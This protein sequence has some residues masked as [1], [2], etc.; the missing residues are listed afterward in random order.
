MMVLAAL[1]CTLLLMSARLAA[2][3]SP[4]TATPPAAKQLVPDRL[5]EHPAPTQPL[6][7]SHKTHVAV[8]LQCKFCH[9]NPDPGRLMTFPATTVCMTCHVTVAKD[10]PAIRQLADFAKSG[11]PIP[12]MRA[13]EVTPGVTWT[14]RKHLDAGL[15]CDHCHGAVAQ[16]DTMSEVTSVTAMGVCITCHTQNKAPTTCQTCHAWPTK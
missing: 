8:G 9:T 14:H 2:R 3:P 13:Y 5:G 4:Q 15:K 7:Y 16:M 10:K 12:W 6:P 11:K 1:V